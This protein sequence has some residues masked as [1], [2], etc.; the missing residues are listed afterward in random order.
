MSAYQP[1]EFPPTRLLETDA[2]LR[3]LVP[4]HRYL[5]EL[6]GLARSIPNE[7]PLI[8]TLS[9]QE[10]QSSSEIGHGSKTGH[11]SEH[12]AGEILPENA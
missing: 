1:V 9:L 8:S 6:K 11:L 12:W 4:A 5:A 2:V 10:A 3:A 7:G